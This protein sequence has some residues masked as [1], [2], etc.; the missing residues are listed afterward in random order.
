MGRM[1][2]PR[3][4]ASQMGLG[5]RENIAQAKCCMFA[6]DV[7]CKTQIAMRIVTPSQPNLYAPMPHE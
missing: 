4:S 2:M 3:L 1:T 7:M 6:G 5:G